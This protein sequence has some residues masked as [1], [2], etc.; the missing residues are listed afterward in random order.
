MNINVYIYNQTLHKSTLC[1]SY[2]VR[3]F[4]V[5]E[6]VE[7]LDHVPRMIMLCHE[8]HGHRPQ[9]EQIFVQSLT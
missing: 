7:L 3:P 9:A 8:L 6:L 1:S 4:K 5:V 2:Y